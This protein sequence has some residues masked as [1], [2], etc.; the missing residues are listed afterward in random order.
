MDQ[1]ECPIPCKNLK[2]STDLC[3]APELLEMESELL[4]P[5]HVVNIVTKQHRQSF[6][7]FFAW[8]ESNIHFETVAPTPES[9]VII[10]QTTSVGMGSD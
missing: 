5:R 4:C 3:L 2:Y 1:L 6:L 10:F 9:V 7:E 8:I